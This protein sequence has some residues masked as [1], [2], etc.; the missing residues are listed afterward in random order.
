LK[1]SNPLTIISIFAGIAE[2]FATGALVL[3]PAD[4]QSIF[5]YFV[6]FFPILIVTVFYAI[7]VLKPHV[8]YAPSDYEDQ[9]HF[10]HANSIKKIITEETERVLEQ[11]VTDGKKIDPKIVSESVAESTLKKLGGQ[12]SEEVLNY[13]KEHQNEAFTPRGLRHILSLNKYSITL[14]LYYLESIGSVQKG[15]DGSILVWQYKT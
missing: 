12:D 15:M 10:L 2:T 5:V 4:M 7:L 11:A 13:L 9:E 6:M 1:V 14:A 3:L 8:L